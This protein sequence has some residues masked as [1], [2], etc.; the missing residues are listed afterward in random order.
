MKIRMHLMYL[1][2]VLVAAS[3]LTAC[4]NAQSRKL[5]Y[6]ARGQQ[7]FAAGSYDKA[8][9]EFRNAAQIDPKDASV[10]FLLGQVAEKTGDAREAVGQYRAAIDENPKL[11]APRAAL[12]RLY[13]Y[14]G[15]PDKAMEVVEAGLVSEPNNA[16]LLTARAA[17][18]QQ[19]GDKDGALADAQKGLQLAPDDDY[20]IALMA[21]LY[22]QRS[23][24]EKAIA[25]VKTGLQHLPNSVDLLGILADLDL[26]D[27][28]P[29]QAEAQLRQIV[30]LEPNVLA[31]RFLLARFYLLQK[32]PDAAE[33]TMREAV[34][35]LPGNSEAKLQLVEFLASQRSREKAVAE[36]DQMLAREPNNDDLRVALGQF[37]AQAS[38]D[39]RAEAVFRAV[40]VHGGKSPAALTARD[41][42]AALLLKHNDVNGAKNQIEDAL[43]QNGRDND[44][45][46]LRSSISL[47]SGNAPAAIGDLRAVLRDQPNSVPLLRALSWAYTVNDQPDLAEQTIRDAV[48]E[49]P[50]D[51]ASRSELARVLITERKMDEAAALL[52]QITKDEPMNVQAWAAMFGAQMGQKRYADARATAASIQNLKPN[53]ATG[54][55][56]AGEAD[57]ASDK[58]DAAERD[59]EQALKLQPEA[60]EP[61][62]AV[63]WLDVKLKQTARAMRRVDGVIA[64]QPNSGAA[65]ALKGEVLASQGQLSSAIAAFQD[66]VRAAPAWGPGYQDLAT[67]QRAASQNDEAIRTLQQGVEKTQGATALIESLGQAYQRAGRTDDAIALYD[68]VLAKNPQS[69]FAANNLAMLLVSAKTDSASLARAQKLADQLANSP[70]AN[71]IDTRGWV[72]FKSGDYRGAALLLQQAVDKAPDAPEPRYHLAMAQLRS[73][74]QQ[75]ATQNLEAA[76]RSPQPFEGMDEA[77]AALAELK[78]GTPAG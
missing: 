24:F 12:A 17:A 6:L 76:L 42:L 3:L 33:R 44:A 57:Q 47:A 15:L 32:D 41:R 37:L 20:A 71:A 19:L 25:V 55:Y 49:S 9:V 28:Q 67:A 46:I 26:R 53:V 22:M 66:A 38:L 59:F 40:I 70:V 43:K 45:L 23:D 65:R 61:L 1:A 14:G 74:A 60:I 63:T 27:Q 11:A 5:G 62:N 50:K 21:S 34:A 36:I 73:G 77:R 8:R 68:G 69:T 58:A 48:Q 13:L 75:T 51:V 56:L 29:Q 52:Q 39:D 54:Y 35:A 31:H 2:G 16:Q 30:S 7:Y 64:S 4:G 78:K 72:K 10:R 18:R